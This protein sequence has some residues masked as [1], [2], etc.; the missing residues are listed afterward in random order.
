ALVTRSLAEL[1]RLGIAMGGNATG[2][3]GLSGAGDLILTCYSE[4][5]RNHTVGER[6]GRGEAVAQI[7]ESMKTVAEGIPTARSARECARRLN[8]ATPIIDE[9]YAVLYEEKKPS[10]RSDEGYR[11]GQKPKKL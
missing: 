2:F 10:G 7:T 4:R 9:V 8:I 3:Y 1:V 6:L 11:W 5:S